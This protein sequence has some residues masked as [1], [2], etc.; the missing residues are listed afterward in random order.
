MTTDMVEEESEPQDADPA[1]FNIKAHRRYLLSV[2]RM[3][4]GDKSLA[5]DVVQDTLLAA[6]EC[7]PAYKQQSSMRTWLTGIMKYK[8]LDALRNRTRTPAPVS[9]L[10]IPQT[11]RSIA[12]LFDEKGCWWACPEPWEHPDQALTQVDFLRVMEQCLSKLSP[13]AAQAFL[14]REVMEME[15]GEISES[16]KLNPNHL[17]VV[18]YRA[19]M[20]LR[21]C[22]SDNWF[23]GKG[24]NHGA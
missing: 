22:L 23:A 17:G 24:G 12:Q 18:L 21:E 11:H 15:T 1:A 13:T 7:L 6:I 19:R 5:E 8:L 2:A 3:Q 10:R 16:T 9:T 20:A 14:Q 4:L